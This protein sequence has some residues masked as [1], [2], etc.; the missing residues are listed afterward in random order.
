[1]ADM[2]SRSFASTAEFNEPPRVGPILRELMRHP[3]RSFVEGW[4]WK[5]AV[6][7]AI[8]RVPIYVITTIRN[9]WEAAALAGLVEALFT[10][11]AAGVY[12][13]FTEAIRYAQP[14]SVVG[15]LLLVVL[16][17]IMVTLDAL[18]H[19]VMRTPHLV[20]GV[21]VSVV[22]S[23]LC[24]AF[25]WYSMRRGTLLVGSAARPFATDISAL[26]LLIVRFVWEPFA[27]L[28]RTARELCAAL[29]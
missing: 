15:F 7:S 4:N 21:S 25:N 5:A 22:V 10:T 20:A 17:A 2:A 8:L 1:M 12:A 11:G 23:V 19:Y 9:G 3:V 27:L 18:V 26:P 14:Q 24:S 28:W 13:A 29:I 16:P 6:L